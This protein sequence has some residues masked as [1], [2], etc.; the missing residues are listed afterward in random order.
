MKL[1]NLIKTAVE[2]NKLDEMEVIKMLIDEVDEADE[3]SIG[4]LYKCFY[5][6]AYGKTISK[7]LADEIVKGMA[8]T[9][10]S[11]REHGMKWTMEQTTAVGNQIG[12]NWNEIPKIDF[13]IAMNMEYSD[14]YK[15]AKHYELQDDPE[16]FAWSAK[17][18]WFDDVDVKG[19]KLFKYIFTVLM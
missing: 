4:R 15:T 17:E 11:D 10:G 6:K 12:I 7:E 19:D 3:Y 9:D 2:D 14:R 1:I 8:V 18:Y 16:Y 13:Y 5:E